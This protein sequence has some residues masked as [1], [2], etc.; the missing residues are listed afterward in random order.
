MKRVLAVGLTAIAV[1]PVFA[2][3]AEICYSTPVPFASAVPPT[4]A[5]VFHCPASGSKTLP[6]LAAEGWQV[7]QLGPL[8]TGGTNQTDQL[9]IQRQD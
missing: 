5:T 3:D 7:V 4:N 1:G 9:V 6:Q 2:G 8:V